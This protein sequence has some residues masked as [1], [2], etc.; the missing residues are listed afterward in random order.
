MHSVLGQGESKNS[1]E[2]ASSPTRHPPSD[3]GPSE[4]CPDSSVGT[5]RFRGRVSSLGVTAWVTLLRAH[6]GVVLSGFTSLPSGN[7]GAQRGPSPSLQRSIALSKDWTKAWGTEPRDHTPC[8]Q[9]Q[10]L[11]CKCKPGSQAL[12]DS[13][14]SPREPSSF[15]LIVPLV[16]PVLTEKKGQRKLT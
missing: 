6:S 12:L 14:T 1:E 5:V 15:G 10:E 8:L 16:L 13:K 9:I 11:S 2:P 3:P 4:S 7:S